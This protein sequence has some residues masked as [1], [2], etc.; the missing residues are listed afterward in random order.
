MTFDAV[1]QQTLSAQWRT[2]TTTM[3]DNPT[4]N[5]EQTSHAAGQSKEANAEVSVGAVRN[6]GAS[7]QISRD[8]GASSSEMPAPTGD[9]VNPQS[10]VPRERSPARSKS[11]RVRTQ[12]SGAMGLRLPDDLSAP[13]R[14]ALDRAASDARATGHRFDLMRYLRLRRTRGST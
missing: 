2:E 8:L 4:T 13:Q 14:E 7:D 6:A 12:G 9:T 1:T 5:T 10:S 11:R 3:S